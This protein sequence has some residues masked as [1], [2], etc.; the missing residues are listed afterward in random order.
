ML[1]TA[2]EEASPDSLRAASG[3]SPLYSLPLLILL[4]LLKT[5]EKS[6]RFSET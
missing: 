1:S 4:K 6:P 3:E 2:S 5:L